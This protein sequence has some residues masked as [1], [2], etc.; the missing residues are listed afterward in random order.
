VDSSIFEKMEL[1]E[2]DVFVSSGV[3]QGTTWTCCI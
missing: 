1:R 2:G 3:K